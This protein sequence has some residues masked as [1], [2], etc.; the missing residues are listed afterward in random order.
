MNRDQLKELLKGLT[1]SFAQV[2]TIIANSKKNSEDRKKLTHIKILILKHKDQTIE[3]PIFHTGLESLRESRKNDWE[4]GSGD[5]FDKFTYE[6]EQLDEIDGYYTLE[7]DD[8]EIDL[9]KWL[10]KFTQADIL[11]NKE[12]EKAHVF[13]KK[14]SCL[15][16]IGLDRLGTTSLITHHIDTGEAQPIKQHFYVTSP[17]EQ[18]FLDKKL[19]SLERQRI[20]ENN[21]VEVD[22]SVQKC[23]YAE[24]S[25]ENV[26]LTVHYDNDE[27]N[28]KKDDKDKD[29]KLEEYLE[30]RD[31][32]I[33]SI[34]AIGVN[35]LEI[36]DSPMVK[37]TMYF[38][39]QPNSTITL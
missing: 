32:S 16:T 33:E 39:A 34:T 35:R 19:K 6:N 30:L 18:E 14:E 1:T 3:V 4:K 23:G 29:I 17:D 27:W 36:Q 10:E 11:S 9:Y 20:I 13:F 15:L 12:K 24:W 38:P 5:T 37:Y 22:V 31:D 25:V 8:N 2:T 28:D 21:R 26:E 7:S